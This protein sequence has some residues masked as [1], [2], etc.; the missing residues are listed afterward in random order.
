VHT[1]LAFAVAFVCLCFVPVW[2]L[3]RK[4]IFLKL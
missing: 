1:S 3:W 2:M 4:K